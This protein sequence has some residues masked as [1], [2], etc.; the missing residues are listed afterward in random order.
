MGFNFPEFKSLKT[1][2]YDIFF[3]EWALPKNQL[4]G[5]FCK[6]R[7]V[8]KNQ[9]CI[10]LQL[11]PFGKWITAR[12]KSLLLSFHLGLLSPCCLA[13]FVFFSGTATS[14]PFSPSGVQL[15]VGAFSNNGELLCF[16]AQGMGAWWFKLHFH[17]LEAVLR[18]MSSAIKWIFIKSDI[19]LERTNIFQCWT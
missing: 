15:K 2:T 4:P 12:L 16:Y 6:I 3:I 7:D 19:I 17:M 8:E 13:N 1:I 5:I 14:R 9:S 18:K 11:R 10:S